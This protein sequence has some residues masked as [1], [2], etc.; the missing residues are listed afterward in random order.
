MSDHHM[1]G[2]MAGED[3]VVSVYPADKTR[4]AE[5]LGRFQ[6]GSLLET[7]KIAQGRRCSLGGHI[8]APDQVYLRHIYHIHVV[9]IRKLG[10]SP[11]VVEVQ[12]SL[13]RPALKGRDE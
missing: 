1:I 4:M 9:V 10:Y 3:V 8:V 7:E 5:P 12:K 11:L 6:W 2:D 13:S